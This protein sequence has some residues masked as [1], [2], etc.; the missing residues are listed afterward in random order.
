MYKCQY[1]FPFF[2]YCNGFVSLDVLQYLCHIQ[3][4]SIAERC[5]SNVQEAAETPFFGQERHKDLT[6]PFCFTNAKLRDTA[7]F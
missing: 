1:T 6:Y 4:L 3:A 7:L 2:E 5:Y